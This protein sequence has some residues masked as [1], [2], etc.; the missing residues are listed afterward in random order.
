M[1]MPTE[2]K[3]YFKLYAEAFANDNE[4]CLFIIDCTKIII[5]LA[6]ANAADSPKTYPRDSGMN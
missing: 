5:R 2:A 6:I 3:A 1:D 4:D